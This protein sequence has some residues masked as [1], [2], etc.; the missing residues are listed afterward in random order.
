MLEGFT[1]D[2]DVALL[3]SI[4][5]KHSFEFYPPLADAEG[6]PD[7][8]SYLRIF[9]RY[10]RAAFEAG[11][12]SRIVH[13]D[14]FRQRDAA[15]FVAEFPTLVVPTLY[16][17]DDGMLDALVR[18]AEAG[19][20]LVVGIR[21]G[22]GDQLARARPERAPG[23]LA[24][25]AGVWY[26]EYSTLDA[27]VGI[28]GTTFGGGQAEGWADAL[29]ADGADVVAVYASGIYA[30][31]PAVDLARARRRSRH[32]RGHAAR[33]RARDIHSSLGRTDHER[34]RM[35]DGC[36]G[37]GHLGQ[38]HRRAR[39]VHQ[40]LV[41]RARHRSPAAAARR[42]T[43]R[44]RTMGRHR[45][46]RATRPRIRGRSHPNTRES[47]AI[48]RQGARKAAVAITSI[49][50]VAALTLSGCGGDGDDDPRTT[51][52]PPGGDPSGEPTAG[53]TTVTH[54]EHGTPRS[55]TGCR[56][57]EARDATTTFWTWVPDIQDQV[58]MFMA[59]YPEINVTVENVGQGLDDYARCAL[60]RKPVA[61]VPT[62]SRS[63]TSSSR[64][65]RRPAT[66]SISR[67]TV[68]Q[69]SR[70]TT[71]RGSG[72]RSRQRPGAGDPAG[73]GPMGNLYREDITTVAGITEPPATWEEYKTAA[74]AVRAKTDSYISNMA[75]GQGAGWLGLLWQA[76]VK[77][78]GY[79]GEE[80]VT[81]NVNSPEA[82]EVI[83]L[84]QDLI[85]N[86]L[87]S[88]DPDFNDEMDPGLNPASTPAG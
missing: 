70:T 22:Y 68:R 59:E 67:R 39:L 1:P 5:T 3:Y 49:A 62:W 76:G 12:Q 37:H 17:A 50:A 31:R 71:C 75:P 27:P 48:M 24:A 41:A 2:A 52:T 16:I 55:I 33:P 43:D 81:I 74:E 11:V 9:D 15:D 36:P 26:D 54:G 6:G 66:C 14:Q 88:V 87:V 47:R 18:Y 86:D 78:F 60:R 58:D 65:S 21:T 73:L 80:S 84:R 79:D 34:E 23:R 35:A 61:M 7:R 19:G 64:H 53:T 38:Q 51:A 44:S 82:K 69:T 32:L 4:D 72:T 30:G 56:A 77:P 85:Q 20:H 28:D 42:K 57:L 40:Q 8:A 63:S 29:V 13:A 45:P 83:G 46:R 25:A 10:Y